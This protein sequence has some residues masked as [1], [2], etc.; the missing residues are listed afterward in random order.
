MT[1]KSNITAE[2][3]KALR[4]MCGFSQEQ[5]KEFHKVQN[6]RTIR[7]WEN[8][9]SWVSELAANK[10]LDLNEKLQWSV[11]Q[12]T[13]QYLAAAEKGIEID[14]I[15]LIVYPEGCRRMINNMGDLPCSVHNMLIQRTYLALKSVGA[16]VAIV[17]FNMQ[18][19]F[20]YLA[21]NNFK[22]SQDIRGAWAADY[23]S[24]IISQ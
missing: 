3:Y 12:A 14:K 13:E 17:E 4:I 22:D 5:A 9:E 11:T 24:R 7:R 19:Y 18:D 1:K 16:D 20:T 15:V 8:G 21:K 2:E 6:I 23:Y 10:I